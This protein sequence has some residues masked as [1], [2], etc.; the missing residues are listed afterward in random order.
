MPLKKEE[1]ANI[2][3]KKIKFIGEEIGKHSFWEWI[4]SIF[5]LLHSAWKGSENI[6]Q[7]MWQKGYVN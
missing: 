7:L 4:E 2:S 1:K 5:K 6:L 3:K